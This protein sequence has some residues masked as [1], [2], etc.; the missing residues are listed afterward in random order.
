MG[1]REIISYH[2]ISDAIFEVTHKQCLYTRI[3]LYIIS[4][5]VATRFGTVVAYYN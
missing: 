4:T 2:R 3:P 1:K 5:K